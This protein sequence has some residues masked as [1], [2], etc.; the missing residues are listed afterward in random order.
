MP[1]MQSRNLTYGLMESLGEAIV[2]GQ[3][4]GKPFPIEA[5]LEKQYGASR[6]AVREAVKMLTA[7]GLLRARPRQGTLVEPE[8]QWNLFDPDVLRWLLERKFSLDLLRKFT[9]MRLAIEPAA[10][11][12]AATQA[13]AAAVMQ[14][15]QGLAHMRAAQQGGD[16]PLT[17]DIAFHVAILDATGNPFFAHL[18][19]LVATALR[20]SIRFTNRIAGHT[21]SIEDHEKVLR[22]IEAHDAERA[23]VAMRELIVEVLE[24]IDKASR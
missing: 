2:T 8:S 6:S 4:K 5:D 10:A 13:N 20:I 1:A 7:K 18:R 16:D 22:A 21:A 15:Q 19:E 24:L 9:E 3:Y 12:L 11:A 14:I 23:S 17:S